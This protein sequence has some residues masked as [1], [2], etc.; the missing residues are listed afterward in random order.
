M[1]MM[2]MTVDLQDQKSLQHESTR[3]V[4]AIY[5]FIS[6]FNVFFFHLSC[7]NVIGTQEVHYKINFTGCE[8]FN[9]P[10]VL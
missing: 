2:M 8:I 1:M 7:H 4:V 5:A 6:S 3:V 10:E 9:K